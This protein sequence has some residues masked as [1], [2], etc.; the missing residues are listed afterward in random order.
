MEVKLAA[1]VGTGREDEYRTD[2]HEQNDYRSRTIGDLVVLSVGK[3]LIQ[4]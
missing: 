2:S 1:D 4:Q 3:H